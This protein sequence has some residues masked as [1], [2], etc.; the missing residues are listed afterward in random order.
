MQ[1]AHQGLARERLNAITSSIPALI[2]QRVDVRLT[3]VP[4]IETKLDNRIL[5]G[6]K[7]VYGNDPV[8]LYCTAGFS[9]Y[10]PTGLKGILTASHC[11]NSPV[12]E[13]TIP[14]TF[15]REVTGDAMLWGDVQWHRATDYYSHTVTPEFISNW[16]DVRDVTAV[17]TPIQGLLICRFGQT[18]GQKCDRHLGAGNVCA[19]GFCR[20]AAMER[21]QADGGDSGGPWHYGTAAYGIHHGAARIPAGSGPL[22]DLYSRA[23]H[24]PTALGVYLMTT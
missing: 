17:G 8:N 20:L 23:E 2:R 13:N 18:T 21:R 19:H 16:A 1:D 5:G 7:L 10:Y 3:T 4:A 24:V 15:V 6:A 22:R 14:L 9:V 12:Y 11:G